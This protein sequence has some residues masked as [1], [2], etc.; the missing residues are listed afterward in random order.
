MGHLEKD[1]T[2]AAGAGRK[3]G[4]VV[5]GA[6]AKPAANATG[7]PPKDA[8]TA[9]DTGTAA[10]VA[11]RTPAKGVTIAAGAA[12]YRR[13]RL[14]RLLG[15]CA[16]ALL[17]VVP[18]AVPVG[19]AAG[20]RLADSGECTFPAQNIKGTPWAIQRVLLNQL[21][22]HTK[23]AGVTVAVIDSGVDAANPQL[24]SAMVKGHGYDVTTGPGKA[25]GGTTD[26][27]GHGTKVAG[28]IA[29]RQSKAT[30]FVGLAPDAMILP[31]RQYVEDDPSAKNVPALVRGIDK[32]VTAGAQ[33]INISEDTPK[34]DSD[35]R[36]AV[37]HALAQHVL[38]IA[39]SGNEGTGG[40]VHTTYPAAYPGVLA[41]GASDRNNERA[42]FS[43]AGP[44][45]GVA[46]PG[47]DMVSTVPGGGQC[48]DQ[49]TSF[50]APYVAGVAALIKSRYPK[51]GP[52][53]II[54]R[55]EQTAQ[56]TSLGRTNFVGWGVVDPV[57][58]V[59]DDSP[60]VTQAT[61]DKGLA[62]SSGHVIPA[63]LTFGESRRAHDRRIATYVLGAGLLAVLVVA[64]GAVALR[65][66][67]RRTDG[68]GRG[69]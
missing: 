60:G 10:A 54:A 7:M 38:I 24:T 43:Q 1:D 29:A 67:R 53:Q 3:A 33:I 32:A 34:D 65:D 66:L 58:A 68:I 13:D 22:Q 15:A 40:T 28:I 16:G 27:I 47:V 69:L 42:D 23:G 12:P 51:W 57:R 35:L 25:G 6:E 36:Q 9:A 19:D 20:L 4:A 48:V 11:A 21:W 50:S 37:E 55:I 44:F 64:G 41:V 52:E 8:A 2:M 30:G 26:T 14:R 39:A 59:N 63:A 62:R 46:A 56:R 5:T 61:P 31:I 49:G 45:V 17:T 18:A